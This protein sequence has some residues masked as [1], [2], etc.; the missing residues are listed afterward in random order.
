MRARLSAGTAP[1]ALAFKNSKFFEA[2]MMAV[3]FTY[4]LI[5]KKQVV[6]RL[7]HFS[8]M[9]CSEVWQAK[10]GTLKPRPMRG[11]NHRPAVPIWQSSLLTLNAR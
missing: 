3:M 10:V 5:V 4:N 6:A 11:P 2:L 1:N 8:V 7:V 9:K